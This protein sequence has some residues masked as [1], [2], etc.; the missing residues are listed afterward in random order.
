MYKEYLTLSNPGTSGLHITVIVD[1]PMHFLT[2]Q[3]FIHR[4][5]EVVSLGAVYFV[6]GHSLRSSKNLSGPS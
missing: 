5:N 6:G 3:K 4:C 2:K 1:Y